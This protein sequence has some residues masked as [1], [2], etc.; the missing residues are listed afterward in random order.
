MLRAETCAAGGGSASAAPHGRRSLQGR[1]VAA[2]TSVTEMLEEVSALLRF[3]DVAATATDAAL[4]VGTCHDRGV[5]GAYHPSSPA[6]WWRFMGSGGCG[7]D[8]D[9]R[10]HCEGRGEK[11]PARQVLRDLVW[12]AGFRFQS[13]GSGFR[14]QN[15]HPQSLPLDLQP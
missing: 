2:R 6:K 15:P 9:G 7:Q 8:R 12:A 11:L 1:W 4:A 3:W 10:C 5:S 14:V 13:S